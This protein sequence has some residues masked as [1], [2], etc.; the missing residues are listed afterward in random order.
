[1]NETNS[2]VSLLLFVIFWKSEETKNK[3]KMG[4]ENRQRLKP[5]KKIKIVNEKEITSNKDKINEKQS[6]KK[7]TILK[8][9]GKFFCATQWLLSREREKKEREDIADKF[10]YL[11]IYFLK[12]NKTRADYLYFRRRF[13]IGNWRTT[14]QLFRETST[15]IFF[16]TMMVSSFWVRII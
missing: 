11:P 12:R 2:K 6:E 15:W 1:M 16:G 14:T 7:K 9:L 8:S 10:R 3:K 5:T 4:T 13:K